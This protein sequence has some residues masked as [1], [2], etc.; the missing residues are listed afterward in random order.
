MLG[1]D[2]VR[3]AQWAAVV[4]EVPQPVERFDPPEGLSAEVLA[5]WT[6][7]APHAF[8]TRTLTRATAVSF[9]RYC[10]AAVLEQRLGLT[11]PGGQDHRGLLRQINA[12]EL[13]F[14]LTPCGKA[15]RGEQKQA[16]PESKLAKYRRG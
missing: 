7:Q 4:P 16:Q 10:R 13:Q 6:Q 2:G 5:V 9:E 1:I 8:E 12:Y 3:P 11:A 14:L 15:M